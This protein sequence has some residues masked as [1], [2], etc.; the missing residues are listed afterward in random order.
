VSRSPPPPPGYY[1]PLVPPI[2]WDFLGDRGTTEDGYR[3][4]IRFGHHNRRWIAFV[5]PPNGDY[6]TGTAPSTVDAKRA[7]IEI[8]RKLRAGA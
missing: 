7:A 2:V 5:Y 1:P 8:I 4:S 6:H 3:V